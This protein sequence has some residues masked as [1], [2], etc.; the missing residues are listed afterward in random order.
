MV[1]VVTD[2]AVAR[3]EIPVVMEEND[4]SRFGEG[5]SE[6]LEPVLFHAGIAMGNGDGAT[7]A[8]LPLGLEKP[9]S[10]PIAALDL[11]RYVAPLDHT[12]RRARLDRR[13]E[14]TVQRPDGRLS[15]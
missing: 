2:R 11:K 15:T 1:D 10:E 12:T 13:G 5:T 8:P 14:P 4:E 7:P 9:T 6:A 3:P